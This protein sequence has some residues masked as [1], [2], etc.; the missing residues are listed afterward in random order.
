MYLSW[1]EG[2]SR[3]D[4]MTPQGS[5]EGGRIVSDSRWLRLAVFFVTIV[6]VSTCAVITLVSSV[7]LSLLNYHKTLLVNINI[8]LLSLSCDEMIVPS[9]SFIIYNFDL[10]YL[11]V[12]PITHKN[13]LLFHSLKENIKAPL[14]RHVQLLKQDSLEILINKKCN[15]NCIIK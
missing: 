4:S 3:E 2:C 10:Y 13:I 12:Y 11:F 1:V 15:A 6:L 14:K 7:N 9:S 5:E 8:S